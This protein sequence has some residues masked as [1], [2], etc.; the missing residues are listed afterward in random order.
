MLNGR[1]VVTYIN[2]VI[3]GWVPEP[4]EYSLLHLDCN[5]YF[6]SI[7]YDEQYAAKFLMPG[8]SFKET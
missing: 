3:Q 2:W 7:L 4:I 6:Y 8:A 5:V 1:Q